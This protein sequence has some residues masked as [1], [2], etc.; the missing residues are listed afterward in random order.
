MKYEKTREVLRTVIDYYDLFYGFESLR[1][2][3][4]KKD[5]EIALNFL[6]DTFVQ[7]KFIRE[8]HPGSIKK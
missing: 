7:N 1:D 5:F 2:W 3:L 8:F 4:C 6:R